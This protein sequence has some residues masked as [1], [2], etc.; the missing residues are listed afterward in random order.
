MTISVVYEVILPKI[1][2]CLSI[3]G[4][5][6]VM[7][8]VVQDMIHGGGG[9]KIIIKSA[10]SKT[11]NNGSGGRHDGSGNT[12]NNNGNNGNGRTTSSRS[13]TST[14]RNGASTIS[15][16]LLSMSIGDILFSRY[17][18]QNARHSIPTRLIEFHGVVTYD[19]WTFLPC[20]TPAAKYHISS[21]LP[22]LLPCYLSPPLLFSSYHG[23]LPVCRTCCCCF[24]TLLLL[25]H[26]LVDGSLV[27]GHHQKMM[28]FY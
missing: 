15:R 28:N 14:R 17:V 1:A 12:I 19:I 11:N 4:S 13:T 3:F 24:G 26:M 22:C 5:T 16:I 23:C 21:F 20:E 8:E 2:S 9:G 7:I 27:H 25:Q 6:I 10:R 18:T